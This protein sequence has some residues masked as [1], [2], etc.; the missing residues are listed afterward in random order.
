MSER[1]LN[2]DGRTMATEDGRFDAIAPLVQLFDVKESRRFPHV[3]PDGTRTWTMTR[4]VAWCAEHDKRSTRTIWRKIHDFK[5]RKNGLPERIGRSDK[6]HSRFFT[7]HNQAA[8]FAAYLHLALQPTTRGI[9]GAIVRNRE[10][11]GISAAQLPSYETVRVWLRSVSPALVKLALEG[12][13]AYRELI[14]SDLERGLLAVR[15]DRSE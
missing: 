8:I 12:Q 13:R 4:A 7:W 15:K 10:L 3:L 6:G 14:F 5:D 1:S 2:P 11:L 9:H